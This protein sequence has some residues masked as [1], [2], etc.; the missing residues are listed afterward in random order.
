MA[1]VVS[2]WVVKKLDGHRVASINPNP[3]R[4]EEAK[5][6]CRV[7]A[8]HGQRYAMTRVDVKLDLI[9]KQPINSISLVA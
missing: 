6:F 7:A 3:W 9:G 5:E 8:I 1:Q 2:F 4:L